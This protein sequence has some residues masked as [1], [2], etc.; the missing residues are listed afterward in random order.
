MQ[1]ESALLGAFQFDPT[2]GQR[3]FFHAFSRFAAS[4]K[5]RCALLLKGYAGTGKTTAVSVLVSVIE[6]LGMRYVLLAP[7]GRAARVLANYSNRNAGTIHRHI[8]YSRQFAQAK[9]F[10][11]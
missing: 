7:T 6:E 10:S 5:T 9:A 1:L 11:N 8:Y 3:R 2:E 4:D